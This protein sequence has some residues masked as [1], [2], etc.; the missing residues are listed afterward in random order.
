MDGVRQQH[1]GNAL[2]WIHP[3]GCAR[4]ASMSETGRTYVQSARTWLFRGIPSQAARTAFHDVCARCEHVDGLLA[5]DATPARQHI[6]RIQIQIGSRGEQSCVTRRAFVPAGVFI[7]DDAL[8]ISVAILILLQFRRHATWP[9][10]LVGIVRRIFHAPFLEEN[11][12][13]EFIDTL[14]GELSHDFTHDHEAD[15]RIHRI[16]SR[17][18]G[19]FRRKDEFAACDPIRYMGVGYVE[20]QER[21][22]TC[23]MGH[24][25]ADGHG[26]PPCQLFLRTIQ[27]FWKILVQRRMQIQLALVVQPHAQRRR[28][29]AFRDG[30]QIEQIILLHLPVAFVCMAACR[31]TKRRPMQMPRRQHGAR[32]HLRLDP[33]I[34]LVL[35]FLQFHGRFP[36][37]RCPARFHLSF[38]I[39]IL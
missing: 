34:Q 28:A 12:G 37:V 29:D 8:P 14:A 5:E 30:G 4:K 3:E 32:C 15:V 17:L 6:H 10:R 20:F 11:F 19:Q 7:V 23:A 33:F 38:S 25:V 36:V 13:S 22:E 18:V 31:Q 24:D 16:R 9:Q 27:K 2:L 35:Q 1:D 39:I 26:F 21:R